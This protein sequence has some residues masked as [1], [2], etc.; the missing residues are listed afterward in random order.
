MHVKE[1]KREFF[2]MSQIYL[3]C[4]V[5]KTGYYTAGLVCLNT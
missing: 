5:R 4:A 1:K 3:L 2:G